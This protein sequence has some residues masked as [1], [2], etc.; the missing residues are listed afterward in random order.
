M[1]VTLILLFGFFSLTGTAQTVDFFEMT[2]QFMNRHCSDGKVNYKTAKSDKTLATLIQFIGN[3][4]YPAGDEKAYLINTYNLFVI[5]KIVQQYPVGSPMSDSEFFTGK[6]SVLNGEKISLDKLE[7][8]VIRVKHPDPR[9]HFVLVCGALGCPPIQNFAYTTKKLDAQMDAQ[10][11][12]ALNNPEFVYQVAESKTIYLSEIFSW[13]ERDFGDSKKAV[14]TYINTYRSEPFDLTY[15]V[16]SYP[17]DWTLN[18]VAI[19]TKD[20]DLG[21]DIDNSTQTNLQQFTAG[22]LLAKGKSDITVFNTLYT[23]TKQVWKGEEFSGYRTSFM[24]HLL[25]YT[26][27]VSESKRFNI[28][29]DL[30]FRSSGNVPDSTLTGLKP[31]FSYENTPDSRVGITS[32][33]VRVKF[34]PFKAVSNFTIQ[35]TIMGPTIKHAEGLYTQ[36]GTR[37]LYWADWNRITW[38]NQLYYTK[39][40]G[41]FQ[42]FTELDFLFRFRTN[43]SQ[44]GMLDLPASVFLSYFPTKKITIY[45]MTQHV[46]RYTNDIDPDN[47]MITDW[48]IPSNYTASGLGFKYQ[49]LSNLNLELLYTNFWRGRNSGLGSTFNLGIKLLTK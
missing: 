24:T 35:S 19:K 28:G 3:N 38:W 23:E 18:D 9:H 6:T 20:V 22:S 31:A 5:N 49:L 44:I 14:V 2:D 48:V 26:L 30:T 7:N 17:Y 33:G 42:L 4:D 32:V 40:F 15:K 29:F 34:Q 41:D 1:K 37:L 27:G 21:T 8:E 25:Q 46:H 12:S 45:G 43:E 16:K 10:A 11:K 36:D 13:Y 47:P 39:S